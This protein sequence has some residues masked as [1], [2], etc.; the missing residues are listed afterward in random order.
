MKMGGIIAGVILLFQI[1][2]I[3]GATRINGTVDFSA[4]ICSLILDGEEHTSLMLTNT[5]KTHDVTITG[6]GW[7]D[8]RFLLVGSGGWGYFGG[9][10]SGYL[11]YRSL[12]V[13][14]GEVLT[15]QV[16]DETAQV[17]DER[18][19][20]SVTLR[21]G[22]VYT[23]NSGQ[24]GQGGYEGGGAGYSGGGGG[25]RNNGGDGGTNG[26]DGLG[27][28]DGS[29]GHGTGEDVSSFTFTA[30][31]IEAG[32][33]GEVYTSANGYN[34]GGGGGGVLV[35]GQGPQPSPYQGQ[36][37]GGG[38]NGNSAYPDGMPGLILIEI[39]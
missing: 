11:E 39:K 24:W 38:G 7:C 20:S 33:G 30:W 37:Y 4:G 18:L 34:Y 26:G 19:S 15:A 22:D 2:F 6:L 9:G 21:S 27:G 10:G 14:A 23:A 32:A 31:I 12:Q 29:G 28:S 13:S 17:G 1:L 25:G 35:N 8:I 5:N 16:G 3:T 36:G